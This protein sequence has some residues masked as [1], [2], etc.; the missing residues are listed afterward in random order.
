MQEPTPGSAVKHCWFLGTGGGVPTANCLQYCKQFFVAP[1]ARKRARKCCS[2]IY[3][4][5]PATKRPRYRKQ[6]SGLRLEGKTAW[7]TCKDCK[8]VWALPIS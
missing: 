8:V 1:Q 2:E 4:V 5:V 6:G 7:K 3:G